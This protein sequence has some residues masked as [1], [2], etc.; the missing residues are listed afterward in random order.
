M[1]ILCLNIQAKKGFKRKANSTSSSSKEVAITEGA[2]VEDHSAPCTLSS[3]RGCGRPIKPPKKDLPAF[4]EKKAK[5]PEQLRCCSDILREMLSKRHYTYAWPFYTPVDAVALGLHDYHDIIKQPMD[6][7]TIRVKQM[8]TRTLHFSLQHYF[9][10]RSDN[11]CL[12]QSVLFFFPE[13]NGSRRIFKCKGI[14]C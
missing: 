1:F 8:T 10:Y 14:C 12:T 9:L 11:L 4:E 3:R 6:L 5:L 2:L 13:K 7:S